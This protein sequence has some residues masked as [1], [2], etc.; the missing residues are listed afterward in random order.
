MLLLKI[1]QTNCIT[2]HDVQHEAQD[3]M[4]ELNL[5]GYRAHGRVG[6][7]SVMQS[8]QLPGH[9]DPMRAREDCRLA[10]ICMRPGEEYN[11]DLEGWEVE[12]LSLVSMS[13][14]FAQG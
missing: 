5:A 12:R 2:L 10:D 8:M 1:L 13:I 9:W 4:Q 6:N 3:H 14:A 11:G 7:P